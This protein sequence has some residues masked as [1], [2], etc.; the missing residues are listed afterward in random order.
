M[1]QNEEESNEWVVERVF[2][3]Q[4]G[5]QT[6]R[7]LRDVFHKNTQAESVRIYV[8]FKLPK[9]TVFLEILWKTFSE[10]VC[11]VIFRISQTSL[12]IIFRNVSSVFTN[13]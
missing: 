4:K 6:I 3:S 2:R 10:L 9:G 5:V 11:W 12:R 7:P 1:H 13:G 8:I